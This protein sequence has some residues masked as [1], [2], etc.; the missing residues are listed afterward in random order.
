MDLNS[1]LFERFRGAIAAR[2]RRHDDIVHFHT[3]GTFGAKAR[4][5]AAKT[6]LSVRTQKTA[7]VRPNLAH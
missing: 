3:I 2:N 4:F 7:A 5:S 1:T 6:A